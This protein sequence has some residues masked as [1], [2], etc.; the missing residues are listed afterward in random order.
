[1]TTAVDPNS[2]MST[3]SMTMGSLS[4]FSR[5][6]SVTR[7]TF[8][9]S[10][11]KL[12]N[13]VV[14]SSRA[15]DKTMLLRTLK[16][17]TFLSSVKMD[18]IQLSDS[19]ISELEKEILKECKIVINGSCFYQAGGRGREGLGGR[20]FLSTLKQL[21]H[22]IC[23]G[24]KLD[25]SAKEVYQH[26]VNRLAPSTGSAEPYFRLNSLMGNPDLL[27]MPLSSKRLSR[28]ND[29]KSLTHIDL[30]I[31]ESG[32]HI[33]LTVNETFKFGLFRRADLKNKRP[34]LVIDSIV[35]ERENIT[36][37]TSSR[38]MSVK[39]PDAYD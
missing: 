8:E 12:Q 38:Y 26:L 17:A 31:Y 22:A 6:K 39:V 20:E 16:D 7:E 36:S 18:Q 13:N 9:E 3:A 35:R 33:H 24:K 1:M 37:G 5:Q 4:H 14:R 19:P 27:V 10:L 25:A 28:D 23:F 21:C 29:K 11:K 15:N 32:G 34:W 30:T 2:T